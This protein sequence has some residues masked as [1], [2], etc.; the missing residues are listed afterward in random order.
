M[1]RLLN[2]SSGLVLLAPFAF[3]YSVRAGVHDDRR[4]ARDPDSRGWI[5]ATVIL[6]TL[7]GFLASSF[8]TRRLMAWWRRCSTG[9]RSCGCSTRPRATCSTR[10]SERSAD[11]TS[12]CS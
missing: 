12:R 9:C 6:I 3:T 8:L 10:S 1:S 4:M 5:P 7:F 11:S 2:I